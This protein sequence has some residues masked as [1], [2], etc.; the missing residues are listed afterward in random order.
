MNFILDNYIILILIGLFFAF[1]LI[2]YLIDSLRKPKK[3]DVIMPENILKISE[4]KRLDDKKEAN[5]IT[6][7]NDLLKDYE[8]KV[9]SSEK[10]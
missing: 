5:K 7:E 1:A 3:E 9:N 4:N 6:P 10:K 2:G 8:T